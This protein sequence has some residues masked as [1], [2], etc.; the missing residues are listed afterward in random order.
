MIALFVY[1]CSAPFDATCLDSQFD[2]ISGIKS[3]LGPKGLGEIIDLV[4]IIWLVES[5]YL[6]IDAV[7]DT[8]WAAF[9]TAVRSVTIANQGKGSCTSNKQ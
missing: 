6:H 2:L 5:N 8:R 3:Y 9:I 7:T 4:K 1:E